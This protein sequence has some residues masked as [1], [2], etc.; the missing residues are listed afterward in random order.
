MGLIYN[1]KLIFELRLLQ[2]A[3]HINLFGINICLCNA[4]KEEV[5][6]PGA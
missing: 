2:D 5:K 1:F 4:Y 3:M 6:Y